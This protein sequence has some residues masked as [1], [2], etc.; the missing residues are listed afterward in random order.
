[1]ER[2]SKAIER[3]REERQGKIGVVPSFEER[4]NGYN[5]TPQPSAQREIRSPGF[6]VGGPPPN[7]I[8]YTKTRVVELD[9]KHIEANRVIA[10]RSD[11]Q[12]VEVYRQ[13]RTQVLQ[14]L[15]DNQWN[16][17]AITSPMKNAGK[18]L[19]SINLA[20]SLA[21][22]VNHSV[23]LVDLDLTQP[24]VHKTMG[25]EVE[26]GLLDVL[27]GDANVEWALV[28]PNMQR[29]VILPCQPTDEYSSEI[30]TSPDMADL[31]H[32]LRTRYENRILIFDL[33]PLLRND[34][35]LKFIPF[36]DATLMV[37][38]AGTTTPEQLERSRYLMK[39][40]NL[41]GSILNKAR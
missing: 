38:E 17:L 14:T 36:V 29:L 22:E 24:D 30:L 32:E 11:D 13:L 15:S 9:D 5:P 33:P 1:M 10:G 16:T 23:L 27:N 6:V 4:P 3:A 39:N 26:Y 35:A 28:N 8:V 41:I 18:T 20:I 34:D 40:T 19:T 31:L 37:V 2:L 25:F 7:P 21:K 12:R